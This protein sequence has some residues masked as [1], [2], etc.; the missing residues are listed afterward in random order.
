MLS[1]DEIRKIADKGTDRKVI[2]TYLS[3]F[4][5]NITGCIPCQ[6]KDAK[7]ELKIYA[8]NMPRDTVV[9][10]V[11]TPV[12]DSPYYALAPGFSNAD[13]VMGLG[14]ISPITEEK[15]LQ[16]SKKR[17]DLFVLTPAGISSGLIHP[18]VNGSNRPAPV[19]PSAPAPAPTS[20]PA[21][22]SAPGT[23]V[24]P[25]VN[26]GSTTTNSNS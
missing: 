26:S 16:F 2:A 17:P 25:P 23:P 7:I 24:V 14:K 15:V 19:V 13:S 6:M 22:P 11:A 21:T 9:L 1:A 12:A 4:G 18:P 8:K 5:K 20:A 10:P 3:V